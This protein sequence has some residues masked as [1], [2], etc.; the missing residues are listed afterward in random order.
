MS[1]TG[2]IQT[3]VG[4]N[5]ANNAT[6]DGTLNIGSGGVG[7][8]VISPYVRGGAGISTVY[9]DGGTLKAAANN[10]NFLAA[11]NIEVLANGGIIDTDAFTV[12]S[13]FDFY[14]ENGGD[15]TKTGTGTLIL[16]G[17]ISLMATQWCPMDA[18]RHRHL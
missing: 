17:I 1:G 16:D 5:V 15:L 2:T 12:T 9:F 7:G 10:D 3:A 6:A 11:G 13:T 4:I 14:G 18:G 8:T